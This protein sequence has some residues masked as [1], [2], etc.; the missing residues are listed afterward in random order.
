MDRP[1]NIELESKLQFP[2]VDLR[3]FL[4]GAQNNPWLFFFFLSIR[5]NCSFTSRMQDRRRFSHT[6]PHLQFCWYPSD[7][8]KLPC[9]FCC[10]Y[11]GDSYSSAQRVK[12]SWYS[13]FGRVKNTT[14]QGLPHICFL[15]VTVT[16][17]AITWTWACRP[18]QGNLNNKRWAAQ[19][20]IH[21]T[22][23]S[24][25]ASQIW[26]SQNLQIIAR[27]LDLEKPSD[28]SENKQHTPKPRQGVCTPTPRHKNITRLADR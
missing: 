3:R 16:H 8:K 17:V 1:K 24:W 23:G 7:E 15:L 14:P 19:C 25:K 9:N 20:A 22:E 26:I 2:E 27:M 11:Y 13:P 4:R 10:I 21:W 18:A 5:K 6:G 28:N 12:S